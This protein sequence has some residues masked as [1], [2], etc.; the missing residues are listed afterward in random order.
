LVFDGD[1][2]GQKAADRSLELFL[3]QEVDVRVLSLADGVDPC[4]FLTREGAGPFLKM[5]ENAS[6]PLDF[7][8]ERSAARYDFASPEG[9]RQ[10]S[11]WVISL[12][13]RIPPSGPGGLDVKVAK[14]LDK[15]ARR[16]SVPVE[17]LRRQLR[18]H[19]RSVSTRETEPAPTAT[20]SEY[21]PIHLSSLDVL[22]RALVGVLLQ[23]P[24]LVPQVNTRISPRSLRDAPLRAILQ[25]CYDLFSEGEL[26]EFTRVST[27][28][29]DAERALAAGLLLPSDPSTMSAR[30]PPSPW[31]TQLE[32]ILAQFAERD[33]REHRQALKQVLDSTD[34]HVNPAEYRALKAEYIRLLTQRPDA[35]TKKTPA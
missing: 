15:V 22:D 12:M 14:A 7:A 23:D 9:A 1:E 30:F 35:D 28:L 27:R 29:S 16:L 33:R 2:A 34:E 4:D 31:A 5:I 25:A 11:E 24:S 21:V 32:L 19:R 18:R 13:S 17:D 6:D 26:P 20:V 10:A 8:I 3:S